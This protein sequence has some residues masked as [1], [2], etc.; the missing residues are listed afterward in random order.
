MRLTRPGW[1]RAGLGRM[2]RALM[3]LCVGTAIYAAGCGRAPAAPAAPPTTLPDPSTL[4]FLP[5]IPAWTVD[6]PAPVTVSLSPDGHTVAGSA[7]TGPWAFNAQGVR[8]PLAGLRGSAVW[9]LPVGRIAVGPGAADPE[10]PVSVVDAQGKIL[11]SAP[12]VGP[13]VAAGNKSG[14]RIVVADDGAGTVT[15]LAMG[16]DGALGQVS[17]GR[18]SS[19]EIAGNGDALVYSATHVALYSAQGRARWT[20]ALNVDAPPRTFALDAGATG[21]TVATTGRDH[22]LYQFSLARAGTKPTPAWSASLP[23]DGSNWVS[24]GPGGRVAVWGI[25]GT[26]TLAV[27][28]QS[29]GMRLWQDTV[30]DGP[31][32][33]NPSLSGLSFTNDGGVVVALTGCVASGAPCLL[34]L[35]PQ[36]APLGVMPMPLGSRVEVAS[37]GAAAAAVSAAGTAVDTLAWYPLVGVVAAAAAAAA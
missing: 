30:P 7:P 25:G 1:E 15:E 27:Y 13:V 10:E 8:L 6:L 26:A 9:A 2:A 31:G 35:S 3:A 12:A 5:A 22:R 29:D 11:W 16:A 24:S 4:P 28:R 18:G 37:D 33:Q 14:S 19:V 23:P 17:L 20:Q 34:I 21:V 36:G 32:Q